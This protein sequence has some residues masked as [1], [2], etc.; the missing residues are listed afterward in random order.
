MTTSSVLGGPDGEDRLL[1]SVRC[2]HLGEGER[3]SR[4]SA[5]TR[6]SNH[7][8]GPRRRVHVGVWLMPQRPSS[9]RRESCCRRA[10]QSLPSPSRGHHQAEVI[11]GRGQH[12]RSG[13]KQGRSSSTRRGTFAESLHRAP[14][15][16]SQQTHHGP[17][18]PGDRQV[19]W[20]I[21]LPVFAPLSGPKSQRL[22][23]TRRCPSKA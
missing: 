2:K 1:S 6:C 3:V 9:P 23:T 12:I 19:T 17:W 5:G 18:P 8:R 22:A 4:P 15:R 21:S 11:P 13:C 20:T 14:H 16:P 7:Q 10:G